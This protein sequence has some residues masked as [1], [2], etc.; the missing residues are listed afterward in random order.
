MSNADNTTTTAVTLQEFHSQVFSHTTPVNE[1]IYQPTVQ[2]DFLNETITQALFKEVTCSNSSDHQ[3]AVKYDIPLG[4]QIMLGVLMVLIMLVSMLGNSIVCLIVYQKPAMRSAINLLLA[5]MAFSNIMLALL[6]LPFAFVT[7]VINGW[8]FGVV[9]CRIVAFLHSLFVCEAMCIL[10]TISVDRYL[11]IVQRKDK[12]TPHKARLLIVSSWCVS[13]AVSFPPTVGWGLYHNYSGWVQCVVHDYRNPGDLTYIILATCA[14]F[15]FPMMTM[16][17]AYLCIL[18]TVRRNA[19]RIQN[20]PESF[21]ISQVNKLGL[22]GISRPPKVNI[23]MSFK[24]RAFKTILILYLVFVLCW[25]PYTVTRILW[26]LTK[27][28]HVQYFSG[29]IILWLGYMNSAFNPIIYCWRIRKFREAC[30]EIIPKSFKLLPTLP[31]RTRRR[32]NPKAVY[33]CNEQSTV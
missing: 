2:E 9:M 32:I 28:T 12:L 13:A 20:H 17:Y 31:G 30:L 7:L 10:L 18:N 29:N 8:P 3:G 14:M 6:C 25:L 33:E 4:M 5:N 23:D 26:N 27:T 19:L 21:N 15:F 22:T 24:T 11:I 1:N 16:G